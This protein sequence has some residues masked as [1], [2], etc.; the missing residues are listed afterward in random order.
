MTL[1]RG[2]ADADNYRVKV[3]RYNDRWYTDPLPACDIAPASEATYP[4]VSTV[5]K[6][7]GTDWSFVAL[8][9]VAEA[10]RDK[11]DCLGGLDYLACYE[12]LKSINKLGLERAANRGTQVHTYLERA[13]RGQPMETAFDDPSGQ[14]YLDA[15]KAFLDAYQPEMVA[16]ELVCI[17]RNLNGVGYGG[18]GDGI[19][20]FP[21][22]DST[23]K[24]DWKSRGI[25]SDHGAY[26]EEAAQLGAYSSAD[27]YIAEGP[28]RTRLPMDIDGGLIVS[29]KPDGVRLY[30][31]DLDKA[32]IQWEA[33]HAWWVARRAERE[34]ISRPLPPVAV[35]APPAAETVDGLDPIVCALLHA[36]TV[37]E[38]TDI[39]QQHKTTWTPDHT[40]LAA[41][42]KNDLAAPAA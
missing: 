36:T 34:P 25:D 31:I 16:A 8:K 37:E 15:I 42:R 2:P 39:W 7:S 19:V 20:R 1:L 4:S 14:P 22:L 6:A 32:R 9:R 38:L 5:K 18:T 23:R 27:Y 26:P 13:L 24:V 41:E 35:K 28:T 3:G 11:P 33:L 29:I 10:L 40:A 30:P 17:N 21:T 12:S